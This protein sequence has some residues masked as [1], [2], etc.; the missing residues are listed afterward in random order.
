LAKPGQSSTSQK[1]YWPNHL[2]SGAQNLYTIKG[3]EW[4]LE[5]RFNQ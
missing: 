4:Q 2:L 1:D 3:R 5:I